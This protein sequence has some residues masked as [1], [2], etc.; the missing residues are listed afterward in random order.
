MVDIC[1]EQGWLTTTLM[2]MNLCQMVVSASWIDQSSLQPLPHMTPAIISKLLA[3][4]GIES[5]AQLIHMDEKDLRTVVTEA[6]MRQQHAKELSDVVRILPIVRVQWESV[7]GDAD[8]LEVRVRLAL[9]KGRKGKPYTPK[10]SK[11]KEPGWWL[12]LG[13]PEQDELLALKH[14]PMR[15]GA[16]SV[17]L[18]VDKQ[19]LLD[20]VV[21][22]LFLMSDT[23]IGLDQQYEVAYA[24]AE[25]QSRTVAIAGATNAPA[26]VAPRK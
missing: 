21:C 1:A 7:E 3:K 26:T 13:S 16:A 9:K 6:G 4:G 12:A 15:E 8:T 18:S 23:Y 24:K 20:T 11:P 22:T 17:S 14:V 2:V 10:F 25:H 5:V 19:A